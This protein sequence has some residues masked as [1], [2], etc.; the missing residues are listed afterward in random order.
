M[1]MLAAQHA[2]FVAEDLK[3]HNGT[4]AAI[5]AGFA[6]KSAHVRAHA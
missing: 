3:D 6:R 5:R 4:R 2:R 1:R